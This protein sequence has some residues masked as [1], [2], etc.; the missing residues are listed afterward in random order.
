[1]PIHPKFNT[2]PHLTTQTNAPTPTAA[3][4]PTSTTASIKHGLE[5]YSGADVTPGLDEF[6]GQDMALRQIRLAMA[7]AKA[8]GVRLEHVLLASGLAGIGKTTLAM[9][10]AF[11][12][13]VGFVEC[14]GKIDAEDV[15]RLVS[16]MSDGDILFI[17]ECHTLGK[18]NS[19]AWMLPLLQDGVIL[20]P[21]GRIEIPNITVIGATTD[22][23]KLSEALLSRFFLKPRLTYYELDE[24][25]LIVYM[26]ATKM[27]IELTDDECEAVAEAAN[28]NPRAIKGLMTIVRDLIVV[29]GVLDMADLHSLS[30]IT[31][32]GLSEDHQGYLRALS[33][34][35]NMQASVNTLCA[36]LG[37]TG[38]IGH[39]EKDLMAKGYI[40]I[41]PRGRK[42]TM[43]GMQRVKGLK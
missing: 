3:G 16:G 9:H 26:F 27:K 15:Q 36:I 12:M 42:L 31:V 6:I 34:C 40:E 10:I 25:A 19:S 13:G 28:R 11:E 21:Q 18:G 39:I 17:D 7:S 5:I 38:N 22:Q 14:S 41:M 8:R 23:G 30:G 20:T 37:E 33:G 2:P 32:D 29:N 43:T 1:M 4:S 24:A 35:T